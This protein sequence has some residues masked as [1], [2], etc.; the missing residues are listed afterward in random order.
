MFQ[1]MSGNYTLPLMGAILA[2]SLTA[3]DKPGTVPDEPNNPTTKQET[4]ESDYVTIV[5]E[6]DAGN[7]VLRAIGEGST[8]PQVGVYKY[9]DEFPEA[10]AYMALPGDKNNNFRVSKDEFESK[11]VSIPVYANPNVVIAGGSYSP[12]PNQ[13][14]PHPV[15]DV[16]I[17]TFGKAG[18]HRTDIDFIIPAQTAPASNKIY[19]KLNIDGVSPT[20]QPDYIVTNSM[21]VGYTY[22]SQYNKE[23]HTYKTR[24][25][26]KSKIEP[27]LWHDMGAWSLLWP[28]MW[29]VYTIVGEYEYQ[30][31][32]KYD[33]QT[34]P[35][36]WSQMIADD[37]PIYELSLTS[38]TGKSLNVTLPFTI[39]YDKGEIYQFIAS[40]P[41]DPTSL[42]PIPKESE[43][44]LASE[45]LLSNLS[46]TVDYNITFTN[47]KAT[48]N[49]SS[50]LL[51]LWRGKY[52]PQP[53]N[54]YAQ[55]IDEES[56]VSA[57]G[58][59]ISI[60]T[61]DPNVYIGKWIKVPSMF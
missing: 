5:L 32:E 50:F 27:V 56:V 57:E 1:L 23:K 34:F 9:K 12:L 29:W 18:E 26:T 46:G 6:D 10:L 3:C 40:T 19:V 22:Y 2:L 15:T 49:M 7:D 17:E 8:N 41:I 53:V 42:E 61:T 33:Y 25:V 36:G 44:S 58:N 11:G 55:D 20:S 43:T 52:Q 30:D 38:P 39:V 16:V 48:I 51:N 35:A 54:Q 28:P 21:E 31:V 45:N 47:G 59:I 37:Y 4:T 60:R 14:D 24:K 13:A